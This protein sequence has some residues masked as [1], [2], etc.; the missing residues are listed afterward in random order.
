MR[1]AAQL[2]LLLAVV[3]GPF[4][5]AADVKVPAEVKVAPGRLA[6]IVVETKGK[7]VQYSN[8]YDNA[9]VSDVLPGA[10]VNGV[11][12]GPLADAV[13]PGKLTLRRFAAGVPR[14]HGSHLLGGEFALGILLAPRRPLLSAMLSAW[15]P[16]NKWSGRTQDG[17][18][19]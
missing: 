6:R 7:D 1:K 13:L 8:A 15:V 16:R 12:G 10:A 4:A 11:L 18:S 17:L 14:P 9:D 2:A 19:Q 5:L 3:G